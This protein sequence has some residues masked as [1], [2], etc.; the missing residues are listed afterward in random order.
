MDIHLKVLSVIK[1]LL[2]FPLDDRKG[3]RYVKNNK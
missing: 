3:Y 2:I 1:L